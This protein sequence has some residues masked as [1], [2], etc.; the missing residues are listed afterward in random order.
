MLH[1]IIIIGKSSGGLKKHLLNNPEY[2]RKLDRNDKT[3]YVTPYFDDKFFHRKIIR[4]K[5]N[6]DGYIKDDCLGVEFK[7]RGINY[8][9][10]IENRINELQKLYD[11]IFKDSCVPEKLLKK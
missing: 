7:C 11:K 6:E 1:I 10:T 2:L 8:Y 9:I 5:L 4:P 3:I